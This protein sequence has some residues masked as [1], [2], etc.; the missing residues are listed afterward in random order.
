MIENE[1]ASFLF[2]EPMNAYI[3]LRAIDS[4]YIPDHACVFPLTA[5]DCS[6][7]DGP[8]EKLKAIQ[9]L[10]NTPSSW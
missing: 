4:S 5:K 7:T 2:T 3:S 10:T 9:Y 8:S 6:L 1:L